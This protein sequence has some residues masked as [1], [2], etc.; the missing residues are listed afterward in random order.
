[1]L[2]G[3][4][5]IYGLLAYSVKQRTAEIGVRIALGASRRRVLGMILRQGLQL[6]IIGMGIGLSGAL[7]LTRILAFSLYGVS[8][9]DPVNFAAAL[10]LLLLVTIAASLIPAMRAASLDPVRTLRYE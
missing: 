10:A 3:L 8:R 1:L 7:A 6:A 5:G 2:L 9:F 4:V